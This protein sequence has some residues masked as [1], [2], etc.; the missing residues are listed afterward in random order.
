[1]RKF[2]AWADTDHLF[3]IAPL[4][5][6][7]FILLGLWSGSSD[8]AYNQWCY[9]NN[10]HQ[11]DS[12]RSS[13]LVSARLELSFKPRLYVFNPSGDNE[14]WVEYDLNASLAEQ[15]RLNF[16]KTDRLH[17]AVFYKQE[18]KESVIEDLECEDIYDF[19]SNV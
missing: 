9:K 13:M 6:Q 3:E 10:L 11:P 4:S 5:H 7:E 12:F 19:S 1:M 15:S 17:F 18:S 8:S 16:N 2:L 14:T